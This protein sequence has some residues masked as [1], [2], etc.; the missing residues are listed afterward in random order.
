MCRASARTA[1]AAG[2]PTIIDAAFLKAWQRRLFAE[3]AAELRIPFVIVTL[4]GTPDEWRERIVHRLQGANDASDANLDVLEHQLRT[5]EPL[6]A[7]ERAVAIEYG[8]GT[9]LTQPQARQ[10]WNEILARLAGAGN[11]TPATGH[12][13]TL[14]KLPR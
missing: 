8:T 14:R 3:L 13:Q 1:T 9:Q 5:Q 12:R 4:A 7:E 10:R 11:G 6:T 2:Y